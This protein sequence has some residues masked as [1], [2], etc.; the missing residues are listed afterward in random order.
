MKPELN[1][2]FERLSQSRFRAKFHLESREMQIL[3]E[4]GI[5]AVMRHA[6]ELIFQRLAPKNIP[7]D[8]RQTPWRGHPVFVAQHATG[9]CCR[10]CLWKW[11][12][13]AK[14]KSLDEREMEY[15]LLVIR[16]WLERRYTDSSCV[17][18]VQGEL[19]E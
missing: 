7:N 17:S 10:G 5:D 6:R 9:C 13:I 19:F 15:V 1:Q 3:R 11:H 14:G 18:Q 8:G 12:G 2:L 4:K 16:E